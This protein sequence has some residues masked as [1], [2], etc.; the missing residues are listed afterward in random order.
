MEDARRFGLDPDAVES[1]LE[2]ARDDGDGV[3][4]E[5]EPAVRSFLAV[6]SQ[7]RVSGFGRVT[8]LDYAGVRA[9]LAMAGIASSPELFAALRVMEAEAIKALRESGA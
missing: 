7:W 3:W 1:A 9:G 6:A 2:A 4:R 8:G 5:N